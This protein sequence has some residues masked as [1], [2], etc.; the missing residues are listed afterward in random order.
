MDTKKKIITI[1]TID[2]IKLIISN[3]ISL[4]LINIPLM[5]EI[6]FKNRFF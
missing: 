6:K 4:D 1:E 5:D 2:K 3:F